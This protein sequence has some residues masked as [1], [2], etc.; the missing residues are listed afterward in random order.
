MDR[1]MSARAEFCVVMTTVGAEKDADTIAEAL[2]AQQLAAC[3]QII[4]M[5]SRY[6]WDGEVRKEAECLMI[7]KAKC[8]DYADLAVAIAGLHP[9]EVPEILKLDVKDGNPAYLDWM[10]ATTR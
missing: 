5:S 7:I 4:P 6:I 1:R 10:R 2:V 9:Y 8:V 3:V